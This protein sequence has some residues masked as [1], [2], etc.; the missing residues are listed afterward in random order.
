MQDNT[1][2]ITT[3]DHTLEVTLTGTVAEVHC[4]QGNCPQTKIRV[5][6]GG[7]PSDVPAPP[8]QRIGAT[9]DKDGNIAL[10][11]HFNNA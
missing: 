11:L 5:P 2:V 1:I 8:I 7:Q 4:T 3:D 6:V 10:H 9:R